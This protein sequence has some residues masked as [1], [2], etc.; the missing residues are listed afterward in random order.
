V[1]CIKDCLS[2]KSK[3]NL[4]FFSHWKQIH[5]CIYSTSTNLEVSNATS[6]FKWCWNLELGMDR[7][8]IHVETWNLTWIESGFMCA[9]C[10]V[11]CQQHLCAHCCVNFVDL[12]WGP[13]NQDRL[14]LI[15]CKTSKRYSPFWKT[16]VAKVNSHNPIWFA[17]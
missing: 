12:G 15:T 13:R 11:C 4:D 6:H 9:L 16:T 14:Q 10:D 5:Y 2:N 7:I 3:A 1:H 8:L 17:W